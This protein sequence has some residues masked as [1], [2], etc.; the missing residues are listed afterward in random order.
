MITT[1]ML[2]LVYTTPDK[3][4]LTRSEDVKTLIQNF[5]TGTVIPGEIVNNT[6]VQSV[7]TVLSAESFFL[8]F[9]L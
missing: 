2:Y 9:H 4:E 7:E 1:L 3:L 6:Q 5:A 8:H